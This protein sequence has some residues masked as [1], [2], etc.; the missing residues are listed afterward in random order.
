MFC[1]FQVEQIVWSII[2]NVMILSQTL[3][4]PGFLVW[5]RQIC[6]TIPTIKR[7]LFGISV[8]SYQ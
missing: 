2:A 3:R 6:E 5:T 8:I 7:W 4:K 1:L